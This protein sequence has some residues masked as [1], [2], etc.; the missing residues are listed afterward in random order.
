MK[1]M[2]AMSA[3]VAATVLSAQDVSYRIFLGTFSK[4][5]NEVGIKRIA[6]KIKDKIAGDSRLSSGLYTT[7]SGQ[8][9][10]YVDTTAMS[11]AEANSILADFKRMNGHSDAYMKEK[12][13]TPSMAFSSESVDTKAQTETTTEMAASN[14]QTVDPIQNGTLTLNQVVK[15][16]LAENPDLK[17]TEFAY[18][19]VGKDLKIAKNAYYPTLDASVS[20]GYEKKRRR[21][22]K[23][24]KS[25]IGDGEVM[26]GSLTLV[27]NL[28]NGGADKNRINSQS[29]RLDSAA[30]SVAQKADRLALDTVNAYIEVIK[31]KKILEIEELNVKNHQGIYNQIKERAQSGYGVASEERQAGSRFT[32]AQSNYI[33]AKNNYDDA[34][35]TFQKLYGKPVAAENLVMPDFNIPLPATEQVVYDKSMLCNPSLLVQRSNIAMAESVIKEKNAP[36]LPKVDL[37]VSGTHDGT[38]VLYN[39]YKEDTFDALVRVNYNLY[40]KGSDK[41]DKEK[42]QL[43]L[44][45]EQHTMDNLVRGLTEALKFSWQNYTY[46]QEKMAYLNQHV[47][48]AKATLDSYQDE[49]RIG[50]RDLINLLDAETEYNTALKEIINTETTLLYAKYRILDNMG[51]IS[52]SFEPGFAKRYIQGACSIQ[53]DLK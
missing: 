36:F 52:D 5:G 41:L 32:L 20:Y 26:N 13:G 11:Q 6:D 16:I 30:Y 46:S 47:E 34:I 43:A 3:L 17:A 21:E 1:K 33:A 8:R 22:N 44:Q 50:R 29:A 45:Q 39:H 12:E 42:S 27:E 9:I 7:N 40:N 24:E 18:L 49:F 2:I 14:T 53:N 19:Q 28:Y 10:L 31:T 37:V 38:D 23:N 51:M 4:S 15:T 35:S 25:R 48:Y